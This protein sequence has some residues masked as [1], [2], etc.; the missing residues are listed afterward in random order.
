MKETKE[1]YYEHIGSISGF[2]AKMMEKIDIPDA[3][4]F[5]V[6]P[7]LNWDNLIV[8]VSIIALAVKSKNE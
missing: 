1:E 7:L 5:S 8:V 2:V 4:C 3:I 6:L